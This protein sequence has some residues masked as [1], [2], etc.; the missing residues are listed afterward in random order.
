MRKLFAAVLVA[1]M[2]SGVGMA[3]ACVGKTLYVGISGAE[4][5]QLLAEMVSVLVAERTGTAVK[6]VTYKDSGEMYQA[7]KQG[8]VGLII[9][10]TDRALDVMRLPKERDAQAAFET[11]KRE[12]RKSLNM[13]W[14][15]PFGMV[16]G[17]GQPQLYAPVLSTDV[18]GNL[19][20]LPK[21]LGKLSGILNDGSSARL[22][23]A[24]K[25]DEKPKSVARDFLKS[26][27]L[28]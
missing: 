18:M 9:E 10:N 16:R 17:A 13:V 14:L 20:A 22:L 8:K 26:K 3:H 24:V 23:R 2:I 7:M 21:L 28:I 1:V 25:G 12:Y 11:V 5:E 27:K 19:P 4:N 15:A 6:V